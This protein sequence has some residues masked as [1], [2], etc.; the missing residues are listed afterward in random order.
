MVFWGWQAAL[1]AV[2]IPMAVAYELARFS[3][4]R[5]NLTDTDFNRIADLTAVGLLVVVVY[6]F[7]ANLFHGIYGILQWLPLVLFALPLAQAYSGRAGIRLTAL[8]LTIRHAEAS[9]QVT[10]QRTIDIA[11]PYLVVCLLSAST[12]PTYGDWFYPGLWLLAGWGLWAVRPRRYK[13]IVWF[14]SMSLALGVAFSGQNAI[15]ALRASVE[16]IFMEWF[17]E[18]F[19]ALQS[20]FRSYTAI[21]SIGKLK[22]SDRIVLRVRPGKGKAV[23]RLL[24]E[25]SYQILSNDTWLAGNTKFTPLVGERGGTRWTLRRPHT[26]GRSVKVSGYLR[27]GEGLLSVPQGTT[28]VDSE[29]VHTL[30]ANPLGALRVQRGPDL[31]SYEAFFDPS[32]SFLVSPEVQ[33]RVIPVT[34]QAYFALLAAKLGLN[35][36]SGEQVVERIKRHFAGY[37]YSLDLGQT[38]MSLRDFL[39]DVRAGHCE[40]FATATV[41][42]LRAA[43]VP[44]RYAAGYS[45]QEYSELEEAF[46]VRRRHAHT[47]A[48]AWIDGR[49]LEVDTT[50]ATWVDVEEQAAP[51]W[52][53]VYDVLSWLRHQMSTT[54]PRGGD[55]GPT[56]LV[57]LLPALVGLLV[58]RVLK[59]RRLAYAH[60]GGLQ[61]NAERQGLD[62]EFYVIE[63]QLKTAG[64]ERR[65]GETTRYWLA[66][67]AHEGLLPG[68]K[69]L[70]GT[71]LPLHYVHRFDPAGLSVFERRSLRMA[72]RAWL[73][74]YGDPAKTSR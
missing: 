46:V 70:L 38:S 4:W 48:L 36:L 74:S 57:W 7:D 71:I 1:L 49:W 47:W 66:R 67:N 6:Q 63:Q 39:F 64:L 30:L 21:G 17:Q 25:T 65:E 73:R 41:L 24:H 9:Q 62:S 23:P 44:A 8:F 52:M 37:G 11:H 13:A 28:H 29:A 10:E 35:G 40:Y 43:G 33:D 72:T 20:P 27:R 45:V 54:P 60:T 16:P 53:P 18:R 42:L 61:H 68:S 56:I 59:R 31:L 3:R 12:T 5:L 55:S 58:W 22:V 32:G 69:E 14:G 15:V 34:Q 26:Q 2:A 50:P 19:W 51:W